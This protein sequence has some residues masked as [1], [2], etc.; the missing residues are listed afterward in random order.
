M[1]AFHSGRIVGP[2]Q[3]KSVK[4]VQIT[5]GPV[6]NV[7]VS[8]CQGTGELNRAVLEERISERM[9]ELMR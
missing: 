7:S 3:E 6:V 4:V 8:Q 1:S 5:E 9:L 2:I